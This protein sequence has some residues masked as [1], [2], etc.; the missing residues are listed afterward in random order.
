METLQLVPLQRAKSK[1]HICKS[2]GTWES[3]ELDLRLRFLVDAAPE[4]NCIHVTTFQHPHPLH[5]CLLPQDKQEAGPPSWLAMH[6]LWFLPELGPQWAWFSELAPLV[7]RC[8]GSGFSQRP[9]PAPPAAQRWKWFDCGV[10]CVSKAGRVRIQR[11]SLRPACYLAGGKEMGGEA[12]AVK[13]P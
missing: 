7:C 9:S 5:Y 8:L 3:A 10:A 12:C 6:W 2:M 13:K 4:E 1:W 11:Q